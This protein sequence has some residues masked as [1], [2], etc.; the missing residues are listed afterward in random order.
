MTERRSSWWQRR[1]RTSLAIICVASLGAFF[2]VVITSLEPF[3]ERLAPPSPLSKKRQVVDRSGR[4]LSYTFSTGFNLSDQRHLYQI[5]EL[6]THAFIEAEDKRFFQHTGFDWRARLHAVWQNVKALRVVRGASTIS[7]QV[8]RMLH[9]RPRTVWS[10]ALEGIEATILESQFSKQEILEFYLNQVPFAANRRGVV[11]ASRHFWD[12]DLE[13]LNEREQLA[14][15]VMVRAPERL[16]LRKDPNRVD[17][18]IAQ[19][20]SRLRDEEVIT[21]EQ[22]DSIRSQAF[23]LS[24]GS[25][26]VRVDHF[27]RYINS[28]Q[29][30]TSL[31]KTW[32]TI[33]SEVQRAAQKILDNRVADLSK[34]GVSDGAV[35]VVDN[36]T[37]EVLA[38][39]NAGEFGSSEGSQID[40]ILTP[41]QPGS[42]LKPFLYALALSQGWTAATIL[43]DS[44]L[45]EA[46]GA[47]LHTYRNYSRIHY[48][49]VSLREAL[50]NSL[51][52]PAIRTAHHVGTQDLLQFL[53]QSGFASLTKPADFY[54]E[55]LALGNGEVT[56]FELVQAYAALANRGVWRSLQV[57]RGGTESQDKIHNHA[58]VTPEVGSILGDI[59]SDPQARRREFGSDSLLR[60]PIQTAIKTGTS[61]DY[62]DAWAI[63]YSEAFTVGVWMGNLNRS[64]MSEISG[65]RG[66]TLVL[67]S[68]FAELHRGR[69]TK[70][71]Y[72][73]PTLTHRSVCPITGNLVNESCPHGQEIFTPGSEPTS[74]CPENHSESQSVEGL[75]AL[76]TRIR[77]IMPTPGLNLARDPRIPD[78][79]EAIPFEIEAPSDITHVQWLVD[80]QEIGTSIGTSRK[81]SW[82]LVVGHHT[83]RA[84]V[85]AANGGFS[86]DTAP[87]GFWV[88]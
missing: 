4:P 52:I 1:G 25:L 39:V 47:G 75:E 68:I 23:T 21:N 38:W 35:L 84:R 58:L 43:D 26:P 24:Q 53:R 72:L 50:G 22:Q 11:Q 18:G 61:T 20:A 83:V 44:P 15:A 12:R 8:V 29:D 3:P 30:D 31:G 64:S 88:R 16:D 32:T 55:G 80:D 36:R 66:P 17:R 87:I 77:I 60:L 27:V 74:V 49:D 45:S 51:N 41:R 70:P 34:R 10:R 56:L 13:T 67:R 81:F 42:T 28:L 46:V 73:A 82:P 79:L 7:E 40:A 78:H 14:L 48:G 63:G 76:D 2:V 57:V 37:A 69:D 19:L 5:P 62:R 65:A 33:D 6:L 86:L 59:L 9:P 85:T 54:G 71:L